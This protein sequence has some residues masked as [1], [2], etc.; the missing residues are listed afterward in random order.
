VFDDDFDDDDFDSDT[1]GKTT[2][3]RSG[4]KQLAMHMV[5]PV[6]PAGEFDDDEIVKFF[7]L[8]YDVYG[9]D[10]IAW[11]LGW[12]QRKL[13][14]FLADDER[15]ALLEMLR[16]AHHQGMER[17]VYW[18]GRRGNV[19]AARLWLFCQARH[20]GWADTRQVHV[21][22]QTRQEVLI[23]IAQGV[24]QSINAG[25]IEHGE[26]AI[27]ALQQAYLDDD[28]VEATVVDAD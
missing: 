21:T 24:Q 14:Q 3:V 1:S 26:S 20:R 8:A 2:L 18:A 4:A 25:V 10:E 13:K 9:P 11:N 22:A 5:M 6:D 27:L 7:E 15:I 12:S 23:S 28:I 16:E 19:T 17:A